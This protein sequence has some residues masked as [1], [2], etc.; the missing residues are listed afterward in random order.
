ML[1]NNNVVPGTLTRSRA[2]FA[3]IAAT[4]LA[5]G[6]ISEASAKSRHHRHHHHHH[7]AASKAQTP[8]S[9]WL[10]S[11]AS[12]GSQSSGRSFSGKASFY[13]S[14]SGSR[15]ASGQ[16][17]NQNA[18]TAAHRSL[19]FGTKLRVTHR[20]QSVVVTI[21][22]RGPFIKG[23]VLDLS[24]GAARAIGLTGAGVGHIT[25]EVVS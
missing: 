5:G 19:P 14:E 24:T 17:F 1:N 15:T 20:G 22:D 10:D 21:N 6:S 23:R 7:H 8:G 11:N 12:I 2:A 4:L 9:N 13:G 16:R 25:A 3:L 18:M